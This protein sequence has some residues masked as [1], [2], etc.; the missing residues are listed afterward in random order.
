MAAYIFFSFICF[1]IRSQAIYHLVSHNR[2]VSLHWF[3][4]YVFTCVYQFTSGLHCMCKLFLFYRVLL[5]VTFI[6]VYG[7][8]VELLFAYYFQIK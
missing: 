8:S 4:L 2:L 6:F 5:C 1:F 7:M 3:T